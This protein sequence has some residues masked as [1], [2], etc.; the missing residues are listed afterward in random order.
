MEERRYAGG[1]CHDNG[2]RLIIWWFTANPMEIL[3]RLW[4]RVGY[5][6]FGIIAVHSDEDTG[7]CYGFTFTNDELWQE[8]MLKDL[9]AMAERQDSL[10]GQ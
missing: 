10:V 1:L 6:L 9:K 5:R 4:L 7:D 3:I 2:R 8:R